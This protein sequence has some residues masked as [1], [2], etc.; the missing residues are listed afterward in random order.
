MSPFGDPYEE[1]FHMSGAGSPRYMAPEVLINPPER[2]NMKADVYTFGI[3][4]WEIFSLE[5]PY[6]DIKRRDDLVDFVYERDGRPTIHESWPE[7]IKEL[8][9]MSFDVDIDTRPSMQFLFNTLRF[10]LLYLRDGD[11][12]R[13]GNTFIKRRRSFASMRDLNVNGDIEVYHRRIFH[14]G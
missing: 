7:P 1:T 2:Y 6:S 3:V 9:R 13:L 14:E 8:L 10:Q 12:T 4:L 5:R 11:D